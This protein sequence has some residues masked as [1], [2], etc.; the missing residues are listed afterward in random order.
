MHLRQL[1]LAAEVDDLLRLIQLD[2]DEAR[3][4]LYHDAVSPGRADFLP[5]PKPWIL[6]GFAVR[7]LRVCGFRGL[8]SLAR[9]RKFFVRNGTRTALQAIGGVVGFQ[10]F[11]LLGDSNPQNP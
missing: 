10:H 8:V 3:P 2:P 1:T 7:L 11:R 4:T 6:S 5:Y 9:C